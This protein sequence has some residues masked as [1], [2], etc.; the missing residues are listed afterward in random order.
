MYRFYR[1]YINISLFFNLFLLK[2][3]NDIV[4][5]SG[6]FLSLLFDYNGR[7][8]EYWTA[9]PLRPKSGSNTLLHVRCFQL[10][11][12][13]RPKSLWLMR[14]LAKTG[15]VTHINVLCNRSKPISGKKMH[16]PLSQKQRR[17]TH[18][19][20]FVFQRL[21]IACFKTAVLKNACP[22]YR[23]SPSFR[24]EL[25]VLFWLIVLLLGATCFCLPFTS[26]G[27]V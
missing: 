25:L 12:L 20:L 7:Q 21:K 15:I 23:C 22:C 2:L 17:R 1:L 18:I 24:N 19:A 5:S 4:K 8:D 11:S 9:S 10:F 16:A 6:D 26:R 3:Q 14:I 13:L 27:G